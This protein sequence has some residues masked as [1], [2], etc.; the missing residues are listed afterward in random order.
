MPGLGGGFRF[1]KLGHPLF[2]EHGNIA[3]AV[4]FA[5]LARHV[6]F[7]ETGVP[8]PKQPRKDCPLLGAH[9]NKAV[10]LLFN[11]VLGDKRPQGG[12]VLTHRVLEALPPPPDGAGLR[13]IYAEASRIGGERLKMMGIEF[14]QLPYE[15]KVD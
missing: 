1:C 2:D 4:S 5:D 11:G 13:V 7:T 3:E 10:Y 6:F 15:I 9:E 12:N 14:R 8:L